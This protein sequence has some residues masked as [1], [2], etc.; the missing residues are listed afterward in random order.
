MSIM[1][2]IFVVSMSAISCEGLM[3]ALA[4]LKKQME[5]FQKVVHRYRT[6]NA[7]ECY[8]IHRNLTK[9]MHAI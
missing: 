7:Y 5:I 8:G 2:G 3:K 9:R 4:R 6:T 1:P